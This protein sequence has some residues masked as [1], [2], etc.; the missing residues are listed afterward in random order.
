MGVP[1][2]ECASS[3]GAG[4]KCCT[5]RCATCAQYLGS[6]TVY[7]AERGTSGAA[8]TAG[9]ILRY[10]QLI[11]QRCAVRPGCTVR[12]GTARPPTCKGTLYSIFAVPLQYSTYDTHCAEHAPVPPVQVPVPAKQPRARQGKAEHNITWRPPASTSRSISSISPIPTGCAGR[13]RKKKREQTHQHR[14]PSLSAC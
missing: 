9:K 7:G 5:V 1:A 3:K 11:L 14:P 13:R 2:R 10:V 4:A 12:D 6:S 8:S